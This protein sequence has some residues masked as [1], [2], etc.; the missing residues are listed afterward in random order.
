MYVKPGQGHCSLLDV[1]KLSGDE[2]SFRLRKTVEFRYQYFHHLLFQNVGILNG[3]RDANNGFYVNLT[4]AGTADSREIWRSNVKNLELQ[5]VWQAKSLEKFETTALVV[6][7]I[8]FY[9]RL[10]PERQ[11]VALFDRVTEE[12]ISSRP[13]GSLTDYQHDLTLRAILDLYG[14]T[15][16]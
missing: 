3:G 8:L 12:A 16:V 4:G 1:S 6:D 10:A 2:V 15:L 9:S 11:C 14:I 5:W 13:Q 7:G